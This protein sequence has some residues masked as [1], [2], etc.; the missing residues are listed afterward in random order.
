M[1]AEKPEPPPITTW[2]F[3]LAPDLIIRFQ[4]LNEPARS[5]PNHELILFICHVTIGAE[6]GPGDFCL[7]AFSKLASFDSWILEGPDGSWIIHPFGSHLAGHELTAV[8]QRAIEAID[9][10][11]RTGVKPELAFSPTC[12]VCGKELTDSA[13]RAKMVD[14]DCLARHNLGASWLRPDD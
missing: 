14:A 7:D 3:R 12:L 4:A 1:L 9:D 2:R 5:T 13:S 8:R 10:L 11:A 6:A